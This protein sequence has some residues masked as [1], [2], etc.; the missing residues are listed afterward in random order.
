MCLLC[1]V[2]L[3]LY[4][5]VLFEIYKLSKDARRAAL[6]GVRRHV[7]MSFIFFLLFLAMISRR[8]SAILIGTDNYWLSVFHVVALG[9][10]GIV[11]FAIFGISRQNASLWKQSLTHLYKKASRKRGYQKIN[12]SI[13]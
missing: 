9:C 1:V 10:W 11:L 7:F 12:S 2:S 6:K 3:V 4:G 5:K 8:I 13:L